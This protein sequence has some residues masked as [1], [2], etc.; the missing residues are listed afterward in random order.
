MK[1]N[2]FIIIY[3]FFASAAAGQQFTVSGRV[4]DGKNNLPLSFA[5]IRIENTSTGTAANYEGNYLLKLKAGSYRIIASFIGFISDT[6]DISLATDTIQNFSLMPTSVDLPEVTVLPRENPALAIIRNAIKT[7]KERSRKLNS[8]IFNAYTKGLIKTTKDLV[9]GD[10]SIGLSIGGKDT[11]ALKITG[12]IENESR[13]YFKKPDYYKD[14]IIA[15]KQSANTPSTINILTGGRLLQNFY[16]DDIRFFGKPLKSP[17]ADDAPEYYYYLLRDT[18]AMD[19]QNVFQIYF[20]PAD[21]NDPGFEGDIFIADNSFALIKLDIKLNEA[22]NPGGLFDNINIFQ[23]FRPYDENIYMPIDYRLF[24]NGNLLGFAKFGFELNS[25]FYDY[26][27]NETVEDDFFD[28][29]LIKVMPDADAKD[30]VYWKSTQS[31]PNTAEEMAAYK[32]ID[33]LEAIPRTFWDNFSLIS[34]RLYFSDNFSISGLTEIYSFNRIEGHSL[35]LG[36]YYSG[37]KAKRFQSELKFGY[38]LSD[39][40]FKSN[41]AAEYRLG[42]YRTSAFKF[43]AFDKLV[44]LF[45]ESDYYNNLTSQLTSL[46]G[47]YDFRDYYYSSGFNFSVSAEVFPVLELGAG[48]MNRTDK[49][50]FNNSDYSFFYKKKSY[51]TNQPVYETR[52]NAATLNFKIDF[53][54]YIEDGYFRRRTSFGES[55]AVISGDMIFSSGKLFGSSLNFEK[56]SV[57]LSGFINTPG[58]SV[59][60]LNLKGIYSNGALPYQM[61]YALAGNIESIGKNFSFRTVS[62]GQSFGD[63]VVSLSMEE[64]FNDDIFRLLRIPLLSDWH[65]T[66]SGHLN[67]AWLKVSGATRNLF[68]ADYVEYEK[69]LVEAG[70]GIGQI[71]L[72]LRVEFTWRLSHREIN[73][74]VVSI[75][76][77]VM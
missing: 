34:P 36:F 70:F 47:K 10:R 14:E 68:A 61:L 42:E 69:P 4:T 50:A 62:I 58:S 7:K 37:T 49:N 53:R 30:P 6:A 57:S 22:A 24:V 17:I 41:F 25:V 2:I 27:I 12:I 75:N 20:E 65:F 64:N 39:Q 32:R 46:F 77:F 72:P 19:R 29:A 26:K 71:L 3:F 43:N 59:L 23:Q 21:T 11:A 66:L 38:G 9:A 44:T 74:F 76:T 1:T 56:Y 60:S 16:T 67:F 15:R 55:Y 5:N 51:K 52:I 35:N 8:F 18:L 45:S 33:S 54:K 13:G 31:I 63:R 73:N 40:K 48:F 28:M